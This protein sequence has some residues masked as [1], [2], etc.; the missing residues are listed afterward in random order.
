MVASFPG[1]GNKSTALSTGQLKSLTRPYRLQ[2]ARARPIREFY[3]SA[4][5]CQLNMNRS[6][7]KFLFATGLVVGPQGRSCPECVIARGSP[8]I[9]CTSSQKTY[10]GSLIPHLLQISPEH[11]VSIRCSHSR[12]QHLEIFRKEPCIVMKCLSSLQQTSRGTNSPAANA[13]TNQ[14]NPFLAV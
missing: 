11:S 12:T 2:R 5:C 3:P 8:Q 10:L 1:P 14:R 7:G 9:R 13:F 6:L 4:L